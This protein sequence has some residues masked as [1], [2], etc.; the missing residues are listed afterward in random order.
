MASNVNLSSS[1]TSSQCEGHASLSLIKDS[2]KVHR[3][4]PRGSEEFNSDHSTGQGNTVYIL[5]LGG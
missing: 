2:S 5:L 4:K 3:Y 1:M